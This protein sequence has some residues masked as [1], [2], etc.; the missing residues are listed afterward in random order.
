VALTL[1]RR[2]ARGTAGRRTFAVALGFTAALG[3]AV[4]SAAPAGA[5]GLGGPEPTD[6]VVTVAGIRPVT[7][8]IAVRAIDL[9]SRIEL[10]NRTDATVV[11]L[12]YEGEPYLRIDRRGVWENGR[13]PATA[14][15]RSDTPTGTV[16]ARLDAAA[17]PEWARV[18]STPTARWHDHRAHWMGR[19]PV[20]DEPWEIPVRIDG[21]A[22]RVAGTL[23]SRPAPSPLP[24]LGLATGIALALA[25]LAGLRRWPAVLAVGLVVVIASETLHTIGAWAVSSS[26]TGPRILGAAPSIVAVLLAVLALARLLD[27]RRTPDA[28]TPLILVAGL[29]IAIAGGIADLGSLTHAVVPSDLD[30]TV[31]RCTIAVALGGGVGLAVGAARHLRPVSVA[32]APAAVGG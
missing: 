19:G 17:R 26:G 16:P 13:S 22:A 15:N 4:A 21:S 18:S 6:E 9:G 11:V 8:G 3:A 10:T 12:G 2:C 27:R 23:D 30:P 1:R 14:L 25:L 5:H 28:A 20:E 32:A 31:V 7:P 24:W 29:F